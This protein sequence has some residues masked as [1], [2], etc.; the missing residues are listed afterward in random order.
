MSQEKFKKFINPK[1]NAAVKEKFK[2][3]KKAAK[4]ERSAAIEKR[5]AEKRA[6]RNQ[7]YAPNAAIPVKEEKPDPRQKYPSKKNQ[8]NPKNK[9]GRSA[10][11]NNHPSSAN[12]QLT[13]DNF[14]N[15]QM[16][17]NKF[18]AHCG[19]TSRRDAI[20]FIKEGKVTVNGSVITEPGFKV[21]DSDVVVYNGKKLFKT[22][23]QVYIL[24]N[25]PKDYI[26]TTDDP[27]GRKTVLQLIKQ[28][29][30]ERIYH[31]KIG[32]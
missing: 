7:G 14:S 13:T 28:A 15:E 10:Q 9:S 6:L 25:K 1:N 24:L 26:T 16:P 30:T 4:K 23:N 29:T 2:Q 22:K 17:L 8:P 5:F 20:P 32:P 11:S 12:R 21:S 31:R 19:V 18:V 3:E 27:Q